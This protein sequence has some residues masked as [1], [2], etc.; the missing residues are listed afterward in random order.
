LVAACQ[1]DERARE[2]RQDGGLA[3]GELTRA[4]LRQFTAFQPV[5]LSDLRWGRIW[6]AVAA[7][8][9]RANPRQNPWISGG[10]G[11]RVFGFGPDEESDT[12]FAVNQ[13]GEHYRLDIGTLA[14][15]TGGAEIAV[16]GASP[17]TFPPL[18]STAD[19]AARKGLLRVERAFRS[20]C[21]AMA[22]VPFILPDGPRGRLC[23]A[24][25]AAR[26]RVSIVPNNKSLANILASSSLI[27]LAPNSD[28][29]LRLVQ[30]SDGAWA[31]TDDVHGT[32]ELAGVPALAV[33][34]ADEL[35]LALPVV[36]Y[37]HA[38]LGPV[39]MARA[40]PDLP[41]LLRLWLLDCNGLKV[42][43]SEAQAPDIPQ[44]K[45]GA[46]AP[47]EIVV[48]DRL[49]FVVENSADVGLSVTLIDCAASGRVII[50]GRKSIPRNSRHV[51]WCDDILGMPF[52]A[53]LPKGQSLGVDRVVAIGTT[54]HD[55]SLTGF[56]KRETTFTKLLTRYKDAGRYKCD[57]DIGLPA[58]CWTSALTAIWISRSTT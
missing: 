42:G 43:P 11:R 12:G 32:G 22:V 46:R 38:Y 27:E 8:V 17:P 50:L 49:C 52:S 35:D 6:R 41:S 57:A 55:D 30:R 58:E 47:Y 1:D 20:T 14:G 39:R 18:N 24:G 13:C 45:A 19:H 54:R 31:L 26:L 34:P 15:V 2:S 9:N 25:R 40:C 56:F 10:F 5:E 51:F 33:I 29:D 3:Y 21:E 23:K 16:Y 37:Y 48:G 53:S 44:V 4:L 36:E 7:D 28:V